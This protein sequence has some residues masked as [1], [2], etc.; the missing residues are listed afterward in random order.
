MKVCQLATGSKG[1]SSYFETDEVKFLV[2]I[3]LSCAQEE[4]L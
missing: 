4:K 1:N 3:G 2:D